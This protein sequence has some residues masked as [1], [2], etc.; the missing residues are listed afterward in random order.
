MLLSPQPQSEKRFSKSLV[1]RLQEE[2]EPFP[3]ERENF[4]Q[5]LYKFMEDRGEPRLQLNSMFIGFLQNN[6]SVIL[7]LGFF[8]FMV[9][10][11]PL[12]ISTCCDIFLTL[13]EIRSRES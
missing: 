10:G 3:D 6:N 9:Q 12:K 2:V 5:Q 11:A 4:L 1:S 7:G 8:I 13:G